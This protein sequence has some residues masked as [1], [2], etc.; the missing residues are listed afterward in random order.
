MPKGY[1]FVYGTL[2][3]SQSYHDLIAGRYSDC[4]KAT[5]SGVL[6]DLP[7]GY[8]AVVP[9]EGKVYGE[10]YEFEELDK[11]LPDLDELEGYHGIDSDN[12]YER[13]IQEA[14]T[15]QGQRMNCYVYVQRPEQIRALG[16]RAV[17]LSGGDWV[18][19]LRRKWED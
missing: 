3:Q 16:R 17:L 10:L 4:W 5:L 2:R 13:V 8:P 1:V 9:G 18:E 12:E 6:Y 14:E 15:E 19:A 11:V 7:F